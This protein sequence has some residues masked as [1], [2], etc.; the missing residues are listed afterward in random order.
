ME[1]TRN[2]E[3]TNNC[4]VHFGNKENGAP[5]TEVVERDGKELKV[6]SRCVLTGDKHVRYLIDEETPLGPFMKYD[7]LGTFCTAMH[8]NAEKEEKENV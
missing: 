7:A 8:F 2:C 1:I 5:C 3:C 6:C 4:N